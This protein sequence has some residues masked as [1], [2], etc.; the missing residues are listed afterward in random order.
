MQRIA[1]VFATLMMIIAGCVGQPVQPTVLVQ[2]ATLIPKV[3]LQPSVTPVP[4]TP[5][6]P[7]TGSATPT[8]L[9]TDENS[10]KPL[11]RSAAETA[12]QGTHRYH[13]TCFAWDPCQCVAIKPRQIEITFKFAARSVDLL[14]GDYTQ[15]YLWSTDTAYTT[16]LGSLSTQLTFFEDG[17]ELYTVIDK[18]SCTQER[19]TITVNPTATP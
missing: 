16:G 10:L 6:P 14:A 19:Y 3:T 18:R 7:L 2:T 8:L 12:N 1:I 5:M 4:P 13:Y 17:F 9:P 11:L 15:T